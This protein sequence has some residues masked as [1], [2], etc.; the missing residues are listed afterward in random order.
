M[1]NFTKT[2]LAFTFLF[3]TAFIANA[4]HNRAGLITFQQIGVLTFEVTCTTYTKASSLP[5]DRDSLMFNWGDGTS[6][7]VTRSNGNGT[8]LN[9]DI[10]LNIYTKTHTFTNAGQF[11]VAMTDPNR[12]GGILNVNP[13]NSDQVP[14]H[15]ETTL[16]V[17]QSTSQ[18]MNNSPIVLQSPV[19]VAYQGQ[20]FK[21]TPNAF[22]VEGDSIA[23]AL[24]V[25]LNSVGTPV[26]NYTFPHDYDNQIYSFDETTGVYTWT[27]PQTCG[28]YNLAILIKEYRGGVLISTIIQ[29]MQIT[30]K[31]LNN[32]VPTV[33]TTLAADEICVFAGET[34][35]FDIITNDL[36]AGQQNI[37]TVTGGPFVTQ[38]PAQ[39]I[40]GNNYQTLPSTNQFTWQTNCNHIRKESY[41][42]VFKAQDDFEGLVGG[43]D[44]KVIRIHVIPTLPENVQ[45]NVQPTQIELTWDN[46]YSCDS[47]TNFN[48]FSIWRQECTNT[49][50]VDSC[51]INLGIEN[52]AL[53]ANNVS[54]LAP[55]G[56]GSYY[57]LDTDI[58]NGKTYC[59][60]VLA[61]FG[62][63]F[64]VSTN[65]IINN[66]I[67]IN[68]YPNPIQR[69]NLL[70]ID[71][72]EDVNDLTFEIHN[73]LG[74]KIDAGIIRIENQTARIEMPQQESIYI[75][76][77][78]E[79]KQK[80]KSFK[81]IVKD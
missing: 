72:T 48:S 67:K 64:S 71:V 21:Y 12:N 77:L 9:N 81:V 36:D 51:V 46:L 70:N 50:A 45:T 16:E 41:Q 80:V 7:F 38:N 66:N 44:L 37:L 34:I 74:Q 39:L 17:F 52:Y 11:T 40:G 69:G 60:R 2:I 18:S 22:D 13:P 62:F 23:Y 43:V 33:S 28:E 19:D 78:F 31:C 20:V 29:D 35:S 1:K 61:D 54:T 4:T 27:T 63:D 47:S 76:S 75:I 79:A 73:L 65:S 15:I 32:R 56:S 3:L 5:A 10:K 49:L 57:Y 59:Y 6:E 55:N 68:Y 14:F 26:T 24:T 8:I 58:E 53:I 25:P 42:I 30:V